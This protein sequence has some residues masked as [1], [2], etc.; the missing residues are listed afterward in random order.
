MRSLILTISII[1]LQN[2]YGTDN[3]LSHFLTKNILHYEESFAPPF[4]KEIQLTLTPIPLEIIKV[5]VDISQ[6]LIGQEII[7]TSLSTNQKIKLI[8]V[9]PETD[10][11]YAVA[12]RVGFDEQGPNAIHYTLD[13]RGWKNKN[14]SNKDEIPGEEISSATLSTLLIHEM[15]HTSIGLETIGKKKFEINEF[16][17]YLKS[18]FIA[19]HFF[20]NNFRSYQNLPLRRSYFKKDDIFNFKLK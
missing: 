12:F 9:S 20:E 7:K 3:G 4:Q 19:I 10:P 2:A 8:Q 13:V 11:N 15:G 17:D 1:F 16:Q 5:F 14:L 18:E 6:T